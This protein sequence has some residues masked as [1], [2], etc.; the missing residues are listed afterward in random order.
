MTHVTLCSLYKNIAMKE[1]GGNT[2]VNE[3]QV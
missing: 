1:I 3:N 2:Y